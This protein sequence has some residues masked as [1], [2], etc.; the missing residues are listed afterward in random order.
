M[1]HKQVRI[2]CPFGDVVVNLYLFVPVALSDDTAIA[3]GHIRGLPAHVQVVDR[4]QPVLNVGPGSH[5]L[6]TAQQDPDF[7]RTDL[8]EQLLLLGLGIGG[9]DEGYFALRHPRRQQFLFDVIIDVELPISLG[10]GQITEQ[11]LGQLLILSFLPDLQNVA[12]TGVQLAVRVIRQ[13]RVHQP[14]VQADLPAIRGVG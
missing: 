14:L 2:E 3:L 4:H 5:L 10:G 12:N 6:G 13:Q 7:A 11:E 8:G 1:S 9:V